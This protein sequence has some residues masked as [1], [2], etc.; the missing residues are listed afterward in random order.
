MEVL[1]RSFRVVFFLGVVSK[2]LTWSTQKSPIDVS[3]RVSK[4]FQ[5]KRLNT[6]RSEN[7]FMRFHLDSRDI[8]LRRIIDEEDMFIQT[9][10]RNMIDECTLTVSSGINHPTVA[11]N[12]DISS[13]VFGESSAAL[14]IMNREIPLLS[15]MI[16]LSSEPGILPLTI[17]DFPIKK[18]QDNFSVS[19]DDFPTR[20]GSFK[21]PSVVIKPERRKSVVITNE[22]ETSNRVSENKL[23]AAFSYLSSGWANMIS[24]VVPQ[25][26]TKVP[27][28]L[29]PM[30]AHFLGLIV[31][32][33]ARWRGSACRRKLKLARVVRSIFPEPT[34]AMDYTFL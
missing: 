6:K 18:E 12:T 30:N 22:S 13:K 10:C 11:I 15:N 5:I 14:G 28:S 8:N 17:D 4:P 23:D 2:A 33:Q 20:K 24:N 34:P 16:D 19:S 7:T 31:K 9:D 21:L 29:P 27:S 26:P 3:K 25:S 32:L 1:I